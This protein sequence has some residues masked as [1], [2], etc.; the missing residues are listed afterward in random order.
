[1]DML[2]DSDISG[3]AFLSEVGEMLGRGLAF[4]LDELAYGVLVTGIDGELLHANQTTHRELSERRVLGLRHNLLR[5][6]VADD[7]AILSEAMIKVADSKRACASWSTGWPY[8]LRSAGRLANRC[9]RSVP[10]DAGLEFNV[11]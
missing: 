2:A 10:N 3:V 6:C 8:C 1:M 7:G 5:A 11:C 4:L 9:I